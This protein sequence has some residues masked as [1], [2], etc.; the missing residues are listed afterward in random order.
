MKNIFKIIVLILS[1][2]TF[3]LAS[4]V[5]DIDI[6]NKIKLAKQQNKHLMIF[7]HI[8]RCPYC[9]SML[10]E[11]FKDKEILAHIKKNF[12]LIDLYTA[13]DTFI[14]YGDFDGNIKEFATHIGAFA[15]P[16]TVFINIDKKVVFKSIG[17]RDTQ[18]LLAEMKYVATKS[19]D[20]IPFKE[21]KEKLEFESDD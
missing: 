12:I 7:F 3:V 10:N 14:S 11:N 5:E 13:D 19:Y 8:P 4:A 1:L 20:T 6:N 18:G 17:Y 2:S 16:A 9:K 21:Y 15:S